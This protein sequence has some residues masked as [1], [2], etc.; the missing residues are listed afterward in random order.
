M[1]E[2]EARRKQLYAASRDHLA[3]Y[4]ECLATQP[5]PNQPITSGVALSRLAELQKAYEDAE[6]AR[7]EFDE[8]HPPNA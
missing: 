2:I 1:S 8:E 5:L 7:K 4:N 3:A 6:T